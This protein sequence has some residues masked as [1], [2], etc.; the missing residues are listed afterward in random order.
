MSLNVSSNLVQIFNCDSDG[1]DGGWGIYEDAWKMEGIGCLGIDCDVE[2]E[3]GWYTLPGPANFTGRHYYVWIY[4]ITAANL[5]TQANGGIQLRLSDGVNEGYWYVGGV[6]TYRGGWQRFCISADSTPTTNNGTDP[7]ITA[8]TKV[9]LAFKC[10]VKSKLAQNCFW[11]DLAYD[12]AASQGIEV[13]D[14]AA[15]PR[16]LQ[17]LYDKDQALAAP[18]GLIQKSAGVFFIQG[19]IKFGDDAGVLALTFEDQSQIVTIEDGYM[20]HQKITIV[21]NATGAT[22]FILGS[23]AGTNGIQGCYINQQIVGWV[24]AENHR[25]EFIA[26]DADINTL[27]IYGTSFIGCGAMTLPPNSATREAISCYFE[28]C[29]LIDPDTMTFENCS[30]VDPNTKGLQIDTASH[31]VKNCNFIAGADAC[32]LILISVSIPI[33]FVGMKFYNTDGAIGS[34]YDIEHSVAGTLTINADNQSNPSDVVETGGGSTNIVNTVAITINTV[35]SNNDPVADISCA[36][37]KASDD[38]ELLNEDSDA[39]GVATEQYNFVGEADVYW[40]VRESP[41]AGNRY[42]AKSGV[43]TIK[44]TGFEVTVV[45]EP[46]P[47]V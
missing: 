28:Q 24:N 32:N 21:G 46:D 43:G 37:Y 4:V 10:V 30:I 15:A 12:T 34:R 23:K 19:A 27:K 14:G 2:T 38:S 33:S 20:N 47:L 35:D 18:S 1:M 6:E 5:D 31:N 45:M 7:T 17:E 41:V 25:L 29:D 16:N 3:E 26:T 9:G 40:R 11:D 39:L 42:R 8:I 44:S 36:I 22:S 13:T